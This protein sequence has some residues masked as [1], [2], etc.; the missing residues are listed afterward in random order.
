M[1]TGR[2]SITRSG[3]LQRLHELTDLAE[4]VMPQIRAQTE[5]L[6]LYLLLAAFWGLVLFLAMTVALP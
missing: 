1:N 4:A 5:Q 3:G 6:G 2:G